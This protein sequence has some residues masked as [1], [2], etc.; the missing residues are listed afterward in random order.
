MISASHFH[1]KT[2]IHAEC[3]GV[4]CGNFLEA[5]H[6]SILIANPR[7]AVQSGLQGLFTCLALQKEHN[8]PTFA[9]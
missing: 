4:L 8:I 3:F 1:C 7:F 6:G 9:I 2:L 5:Y